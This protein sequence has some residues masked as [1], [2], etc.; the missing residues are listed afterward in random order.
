M[1]GH[2]QTM[3]RRWLSHLLPTVCISSTAGLPLGFQGTVVPCLHF[4]VSLSLILF[5]PVLELTDPMLRLLAITP[6]SVRTDGDSLDLVC[7]PRLTEDVG[8]LECTFSEGGVCSD[9]CYVSLSFENY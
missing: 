7:L 4:F 1:D 9:L 2:L 6:S 5:P 3:S 8:H